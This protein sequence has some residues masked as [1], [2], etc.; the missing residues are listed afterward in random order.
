MEPKPKAE[1]AK[2]T[3]VDVPT[4]KLSAETQ[5][6]LKARKSVA[7]VFLQP[8]LS[9][10]NKLGRHLNV[11]KFTSEG[12]ILGEEEKKALEKKKK[13]EEC[14]LFCCNRKN[15]TCMEKTGLDWFRVF[16]FLLAFWGVL[17]LLMYVFF[18][19]FKASAGGP[20]NL[21]SDHFKERCPQL[22]DRDTV[23]KN[24]KTGWAGA[25]V[26]FPFKFGGQNVFPDVH[27]LFWDVWANSKDPK[28]KKK[29][30]NWESKKTNYQLFPFPRDKEGKV[31]EKWKETTEEAYADFFD[32]HYV[33]PAVTINDHCSSGF[34]KKDST[35][36]SWPMVPSITNKSFETHHC[37]DK[38]GTPPCFPYLYFT[39][40][41]LIGWT[42]QIS[43][44]DKTGEIYCELDKDEYLNE[45]IKADEFSGKGF[46][47]NDRNCGLGLCSFS[48]GRFP[49]YGKKGVKSPI[50]RYKIT[51]MPLNKKFKIQCRIDYP[52]YKKQMDALGYPYSYRKD[53]IWAALMISG[54]T[55]IFEGKD[56]LLA[57]LAAALFFT[58]NH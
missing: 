20:P 51:K 13:K 16:F 15:K 23:K 38:A 48:L 31:D 36:C 12:Q 42:P 11:E 43:G 19:I 10:T 50:I 3:E 53:R 14:K 57:S 26:T 34:R 1:A 28:K 52:G 22:V 30:D 17:I 27:P 56:I 21:T 29:H 33:T 8:Q 49:L 2:P 5:K 41:D 55:M 9:I 54:A 4:K 24:V 45:G 37:A 25:G 35:S 40:N 7:S 39:I 6:S 44:T 58:S 47:E 18:E 46:D 32:A